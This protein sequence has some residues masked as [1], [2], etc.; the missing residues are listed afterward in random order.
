V[1]TLL[2][3]PVV[4]GRSSPPG[5]DVVPDVALRLLQHVAARNRL[6]GAVLCT[7]RGDPA[8]RLVAVAEDKEAA[9]IVVGSRRRGLLASLLLGSVS[10]TVARRAPCPVVIVPE[11]AQVPAAVAGDGADAA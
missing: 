7:E 8:E 2:M 6:T 5:C 9:L 1:P 11:D 3:P 4:Y 10:A